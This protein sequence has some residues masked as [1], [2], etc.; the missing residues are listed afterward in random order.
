MQGDGRTPLGTVRVEVM[1]RTDYMQPEQLSALEELPD[2]LLAENVDCDVFY[3]EPGGMGLPPLE[4]IAIFTGTSIASGA[5]YDLAKAAIKAAISWSRE[6]IRRQ[7][8]ENEPPQGCAVRV[9]L[10]GPRGE[11]LKV[12][13]VTR[14]AVDDQF[15]HPTIE[16]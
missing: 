1:G 15:T 8:P 12:M 16:N 10:Y 14:D 4:T 11:L 13:E 7:P 3:R 6:R 9:S 5:L 2:Y